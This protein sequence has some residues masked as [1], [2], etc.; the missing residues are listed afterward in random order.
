MPP[1]L[2]FDLTLPDPDSNLALDEALLLSAEAGEIGEVLRFWEFPEYAVML[3]AGGSIAIDVNQEACKEEGVTLHRRSSG[4]GTVLL[5]PG[6]L[7]FSLILS[8]ERAEELRQVNSSYRW[9][10]E[11]ISQALAPIVTIDRAGISDLSHQ[12]KKFSGNAQQ[13]KARHVL[14]H[15]TLLYDFDLPRLARLLNPPERSPDYRAGRSHLDFVMNLPT[16]SDHLK[17]SLREAF[18]GVAGPPPTAPLE[19]VSEL[20]HEKYSSQEWIWKR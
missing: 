5:G 1:L 9:I 13:R 16:T 7:L 8:Y 19:R 20:L 12:G 10:L 6:C 18:D 3:G 4:G 15:G 14:H 17:E 2:C 11:R